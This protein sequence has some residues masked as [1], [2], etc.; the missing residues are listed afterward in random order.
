MPSNSTTAKS[1]QKYLS[2]K[3]ETLVLSHSPFKPVSPQ[4]ALHSIKKTNNNH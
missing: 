1:A 2:T 3:A 4:Q